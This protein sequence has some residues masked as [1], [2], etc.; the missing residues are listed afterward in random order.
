MKVACPAFGVDLKRALATGGRST[1]PR[2]RVALTRRPSAFEQEAVP[3]QV[4]LCGAGEVR[5]PSLLEARSGPHPQASS[6]AR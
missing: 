6:A 3:P 5:Q 4:Q 1:Q 2:K